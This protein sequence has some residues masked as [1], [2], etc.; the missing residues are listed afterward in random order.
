MTEIKEIKTNTKSH[1]SMPSLI[2]DKNGRI[3][4]MNPDLK[5]IIPKAAPQSNFFELF[6]EQTLLTLQRI[7]IDTRK[8]DTS[9]KDIIQVNIA[10]ETKNFEVVFLP[11]KSENNTYY[12]INLIEI[13]EKKS[14]SETKK[15]W[16]ATSELE[17]IADDKR[18]ISV[19]NK[20]KL[21]YPFTFIE[22]AKIQKEINEL[23]EF[24]WIKEPSGKL[25]LV[26]DKYATS[27]GFS[28]NQL[29]NKK[30]EDYLPK[31]LVSLY[32][33]IDRYIIESSNNIIL[34][35]S[36]TPISGDT[37]RDHVIIQF[38]ICDLENNVVAI[39]GFSQ[40][41]STKKDSPN[42]IESNS[43][44]DVPIPIF[45]INK[46]KNISGFNSSFLLLAKEK[47]IN[48]KSITK[49]IETNLLSIIEPYLHDKKKKGPI[50]F[51]YKFIE[52]EEGIYEVHLKKNIEEDGTFNGAQVLFIPKKS[53]VDD[54]VLSSVLNPQLIQDLPEALFVYDLENLKF[55]DVNTKAL[56]LYGYKRDEFLTMDLTDL[57][58]PE[59]VQTLIQ[60]SENKGTSIAGPWR[61]KKKD[62]SSILVELSRVTLEYKGKKAHLNF[63]RNVSEKSDERKSLQIFQA[64]YEHSSDLIINTDK[65]G[66]IINVND[67]VSRKM[68]YSKKDSETRPII[69]FVS[70]EDR[71]KINKNVFQ[72][73]LPKP[74]TLDVTLKK[75]SGDFQKAFL[76]A[77]PIKNINGEIE[78][79][80]FVIKPE[81]STSETVGIDNVQNHLAERIDSCFLSNMF[82]EILTPINV[83]IGFTQ[84]LWESIGNP[85]EEQKE[86]VD[87]IKENQKLLLQI[88]DSAVEY[89][90]LQQKVIK[91]KPEQIKFTDLLDEIKE[92]TRKTAESH[93][94]ELSYGKI[95]SS[96]IF[97]TDKQKLISLISLFIK[98]AIHITK[99][100]TVY[101]SAAVYND[102]SIIVTVKD[103]RS[104]ITPHL[105]KGLQDV[106]TDEETLIRRN[107]G[108]SRFSMRL[109]NKLLELLSVNRDTISKSGEVLE[110]G[111]VI[112]KKYVVGEEKKFEIEIPGQ[113]D[114][115][116]E[117]QSPSIVKK[118]GDHELEL[119]KL[120]CLYF[121]DQVDSQV[122]F[123]SQMKDLKNIEFAVS[124]EAALPL[125]KTKRFD[126][127]IMD[128]NLQGEYNG[129]DALRIIQKMP[130][131]KDVPVIA[132]TAYMQ[133][134]AREN[135][136]AAGFNDF[137][138]KP[139]LRDKI[140]EILKRFF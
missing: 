62:G 5:K 122:L 119:G 93:K 65:D 19:I 2:I 115:T 85:G 64:G 100:S 83:I 46:E 99:E 25:I 96:L 105:L 133:P 54:S 68:G 9:V 78:S 94:V 128:I 42:F 110:Y 43:F 17:K 80:T 18:I 106:F 21:T 101:L 7:F 16:I 125:L 31:Y 12:T 90:S 137:I 8:Y 28:S 26:N 102:N 66:F 117:T 34:E 69:S 15:F 89:S 39:I 134:G 55:L 109:A 10:N 51:D 30:E 3:I 44:E 82:H 124:L 67:N 92:I 63:V 123:K 40:K 98:F 72:I 74:V 14:I 91:F 81:E 88:M 97:E 35:S 120:S 49:I 57:Y 59:D 27:L 32:K 58:A 104:A 61:H 139:L 129:L 20:V 71:A 24:F 13:E 113:T 86:A 112:P 95:S 107:Y 60:S 6:D 4:A 48:N 108:F 76:H 37:K 36:G 52:N 77:V 111:L 84:E 75:A 33:N 79:F 23:D 121:E 132:S 127:L 38:P 22:K 53:T 11:L 135:F 138:P 126:F 50:I 140:L 130:G 29:E 131:Y 118:D 116:P 87:I 1:V 103:T 136:I 70:D 114:E 73:S 45:S 56:N 47:D 41:S